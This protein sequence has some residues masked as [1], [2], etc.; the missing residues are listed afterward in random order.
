MAKNLHRSRLFP[1]GAWQAVYEAYDKSSRATH[2]RIRLG[3][4]HPDI[5]TS[6]TVLNNG[7][8]EASPPELVALS[9]TPA[10]V[11]FNALA[12]DISTTISVTD[13]SGVAE[14]FV[15]LGSS[16]DSYES[17][18][19]TRQAG[20]PQAGRWR[21]NLTLSPSYPAGTH[22]IGAYLVDVSGKSSSYGQG[23][24]PN[25]NP[26]PAGADRT[27]TVSDGTP[28]AYA[29]WRAA[30]PALAGS[31]GLPGADHDRDGLPNAM[32]FLLGTNPLVNSQAGGADPDAARAPVYS[33]TPT[34]LRA[35]YRLSAVNAA[36]GSG[37]P[38]WLQPQSSQDLGSSWSFR[39][40][41]QLSGDLW[42]VELPASNGSRGFLRFSVSTLRLYKGLPFCAGW[43]CSGSFNPRHPPSTIMSAP[44]SFHIPLSRRRLVRG[45]TLTAAGLWAPGAF[46]ELLTLTPAMTEGPFFPDKLPL[47]QDND[48]IRITDQTTPAVG[49]ITNL[50][51]RLLDKNGAPIKDALIELWQ[52][53]DHGTYL[54][55]NGASGG[56][57]DAGFQGYGKFETAKDGDWKFRTIQPG[58]YTGRTRHYH[59]GVTLKGQPRFATQLFFKDEPGNAR[60]GVLRGIKDEKQRES[61]IRAFYPVA[62]TKELAATWDIVLGVT[63]RDP[64]ER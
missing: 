41:I 59:F 39:H 24:L 55:S 42:R 20:T 21:G 27:I 10:T 19:L 1:P 52:A 44:Y 9:V 46:A 17:F 12:T 47:D 49:T 60:D 25:Y 58:L 64:E 38:L 57:R 28:D 6:L 15:L 35:E 3:P 30:R 4:L 11:P 33:L 54:H 56:T 34:G 18:P 22:F 45:L 40:P 61:V 2:Y 13:D 62:D 37:T 5:Q 53:D 36:L 8:I 23:V 7:V 14:V 43:V 29:S 16:G 63:P 50:S 26:L 31:S 51:G 32:E 48:L